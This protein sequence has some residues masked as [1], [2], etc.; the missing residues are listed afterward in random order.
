MGVPGT[1]RA[2]GGLRGLSLAL[3]S[4]PYHGRYLFVLRRT[5]RE[6]ESMHVSASPGAATANRRSNLWQSPEAY[7]LVTLLIVL[8]GRATNTKHTQWQPGGATQVWVQPTTQPSLVCG[9]GRQ[10]PCAGGGPA[11]V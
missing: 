3:E 2:L 8:S 7:K 1:V 6:L 5:P 10:D 11:M 4:R 9:S